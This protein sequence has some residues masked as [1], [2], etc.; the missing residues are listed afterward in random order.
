MSGFG[1]SVTS[2][3]SRGATADRLLLHVDT[4]QAHEQ[5]L[6]S[7]TVVAVNPN[8]EPQS[9][10][11]RDSARQCKPRT[12]PILFLTVKCDHLTAII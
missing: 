8:Q 3:R 7:R 9:L 2:H 4:E 1:R 6:N 10:W 5:L 12:I 11:K